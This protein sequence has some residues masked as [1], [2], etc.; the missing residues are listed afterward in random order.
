MIYVPTHMSVDS[1]FQSMFKI[2]KPVELEIDAAKGAMIVKPIGE[3]EA[4]EKGWVR[5]S[6]SKSKKP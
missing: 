6:G 2:G 3:S 4:R 1:L 5:R